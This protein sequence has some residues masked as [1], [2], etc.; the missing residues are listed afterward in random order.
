MMNSKDLRKEAKDL[1]KY[2]G[3]N[4]DSVILE[5]QKQLDLMADLRE[6]ENEVN[7]NLLN[8]LDRI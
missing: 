5:V 1:N 6:K 7:I 3:G 4:Y 2:L 8:A